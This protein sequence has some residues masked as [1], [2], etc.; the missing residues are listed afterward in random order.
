M[1]LQQLVR[2]KDNHEICLHGVLGIFVLGKDGMNI[3]LKMK[4]A[5]LIHSLKDCRSR[6]NEAKFLSITA[7]GPYMI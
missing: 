1:R 5:G 3:I 6:I 4:D 2:E 7:E